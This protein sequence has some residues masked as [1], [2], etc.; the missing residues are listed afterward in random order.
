MFSPS[1]LASSSCGSSKAS[2]PSQ[3]FSPSPL[4]SSSCLASRSNLVSA[5][6][7]SKSYSISFSISAQRLSSKL[8][9]LLRRSFETAFRPTV[10][11]VWSV[12]GEKVQSLETKRSD[13]CNSK[14]QP[15][16]AVDTEVSAI[17]WAETE[18]SFPIAQVLQA[19]PMQRLVHAIFDSKIFKIF[20][21]F[22]NWTIDDLIHL[23][24]EQRL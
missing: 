11:E 13:L 19:L 1:P 9:L 10:W 5:Q 12:E 8:L 7:L 20:K 17:R 21:I 2:S 15:S 23:E 4:A 22:K 16:F 14:L 6:R 3:M 24:E 18:R